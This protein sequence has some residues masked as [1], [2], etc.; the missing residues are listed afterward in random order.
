MKNKSDLKY[1]HGTAKFIIHPSNEQHK[2]NA[3]KNGGGKN[4]KLKAILD[5]IKEKKKRGRLECQK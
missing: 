4:L 1:L 3:G 5:R 2:T